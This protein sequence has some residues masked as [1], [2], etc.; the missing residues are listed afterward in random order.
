MLYLNY[1]TLKSGKE[2][3][4]ACNVDGLN[5]GTKKVLASGKTDTRFFDYKGQFL[6]K[7]LHNY[8]NTSFGTQSI[9]DLEAT[10]NGNMSIYSNDIKRVRT[11]NRKEQK[12]CTT[13]LDELFEAFK[14]RAAGLGIEYNGKDSIKV[15]AAKVDKKETAQKEQAQKEQAQKRGEQIERAKDKF[16]IEELEKMIEAKKTEQAQK[17]ATA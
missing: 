4:T 13:L 5:F 9:T 10:N 16:T 11:I 2:I 15:F 8:Y 12:S 6:P 3:A 7:R 14:V 17:T 1:K